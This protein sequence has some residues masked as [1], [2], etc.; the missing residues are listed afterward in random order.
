[1]STWM[2]PWITG[3]DMRWKERQALRRG[4]HLLGFKSYDD[5]RKSPHWIEFRKAA[6]ERSKKACERCGGSSGVVLQVHHLTYER[7][8]RELP[9]DVQV[10][11]KDCHTVA[12]TLRPL[13]HEETLALRAKRLR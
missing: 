6:L 8:G 7:I 5:Y 2:T 4:L 1:M 9:D 13:T 12:H 3:P 11:C 10:L